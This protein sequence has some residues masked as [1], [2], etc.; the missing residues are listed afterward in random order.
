M[1]PLPPSDNHANRIGVDRRTGRPRIVA[2]PETR[3]YKEQAGWLA[4][5]WK[6]R[7]GW[8]TPPEGRKVVMR[9]WIFWGDARVHDPGNAVKV[10]ADA[11]KGLLFPD[12]RTLL[13]R[14]M[15]YAIDRQNPRVEVELEVM[16]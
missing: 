11:V 7:V 10:M 13:P 9:Y 4:V 8:R 14:A 16:A 2:R 6:G 12:D 3:A 5:E 1:L 15:D